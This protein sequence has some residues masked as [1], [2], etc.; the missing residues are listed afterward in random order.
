MLVFIIS[1][2]SLSEDYLNNEF[3]RFDIIGITLIA[4]LFDE[5]FTP[6]MSFFGYFA[7]VK[8]TIPLIIFCFIWILVKSKERML[9]LLFLIIVV[10]GGEFF[11]E[12][13]RRAF[14]HLHPIANALSNQNTYLFPSEQTMTAFIIFGYVGYLFARYIKHRFLDVFVILISIMLVI[15]IGLSRI[16]FM[17]QHPSD[18]VAGYAFGGVWLSFN[19]LVLEIFRLSREA[20]FD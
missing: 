11:E 3:N 5:R 12:G 8:I 16:Y 17:Q 6:W 19:I 14:H 15:L 9:D 1:I 4:K 2:T 18:V 7:S 20:E 10:I 13:I